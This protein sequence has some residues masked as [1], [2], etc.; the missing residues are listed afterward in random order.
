M[1]ALSRKW[2][3]VNKTGHF[4][5]VFP[6]FVKTTVRHLPEP[7][8]LSASAWST[9]AQSSRCS[10]GIHLVQA[11]GSLPK[12]MASLWHFYFCVRMWPQGLLPQIM[13]ALAGGTQLSVLTVG[14]GTR[15][16]FWLEQVLAAAVTCCLTWVWRKLVEWH[17]SL[18]GV[19]PIFGLDRAA[20]VVQH[21]REEK[22]KRSTA[23]GEVELPKRQNHPSHDQPQTFAAVILVICALTVGNMVGQLPLGQMTFHF[24]CHGSLPRSLSLSPQPVLQPPPTLQRRVREVSCW[25]GL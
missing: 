18:L 19:S 23:G 24:F 1:A 13:S 3:T 17:V 11:A 7:H 20:E 22:K 21:W 15:R 14:L 6:V 9:S 25:L 16:A 10:A 4:S 5:N 12:L 2:E 8:S